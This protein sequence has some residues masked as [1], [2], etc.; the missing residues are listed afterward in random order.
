MT[1]SRTPPHAFKT[2]DCSHFPNS[3]NTAADCTFKHPLCPERDCTD[4]HCKFTHEHVVE[5]TAPPPYAFCNL[6]RTF[7]F[8]L[9]LTQTTSFPSPILTPTRMLGGCCVVSN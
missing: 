6:I 8:N 5:D 4:R 9:T 2:R 7:T 1:R 3:R